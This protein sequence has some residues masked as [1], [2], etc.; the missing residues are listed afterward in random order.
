MKIEEDTITFNSG[1]QAHATLGIA[2]IN[3]QLEPSEGYDRRMD[4]PVPEWWKKQRPERTLTD[5]DMREL[6]DH[7]I[8]LWTGFKKLCDPSL[9]KASSAIHANLHRTGE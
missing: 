3:S 9:D 1:H 8:G 7:M 2:G 5:E 6:A 4:W